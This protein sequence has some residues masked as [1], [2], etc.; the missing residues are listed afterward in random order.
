MRRVI[1]TSRRTLLAALGATAAGPLIGLSTSPAAAATTS[2]AGAPAEAPRAGASASSGMTGPRS[3][4]TLTGAPH[5]IAALTR[6]SVGALTATVLPGTPARTEI[7]CAGQPLA[8]LT[9]GARTVL[10]T[11]PERTFTENKRTFEDRFERTLATA[12]SWGNSPAGGSWSVFGGVRTGTPEEPVYAEFTIPER[13]A[14]RAV[15][16]DTLTGRFA[17][18]R[19]DEITDVDVR[20]NG[21]FDKVPAGN[22]CSFALVFAYSGKDGTDPSTHYRARLSFTTQGGVDLRAEKVLGGDATVLKTAGPLATGVP[23]NTD[24]TIRVRREGARVQI[25]AWR[26]AAVEPAGW[27]MEFTDADPAYAK[28]RVGVRGFASTGCTNLPV[29]MSVS[30]FNVMEASWEKPPSV[31]HSHW[32]RL[33]DAPYDGTWTPAVEAVV[34]GWAGSL[35]PDALSYAA[36][37]LPGAP[38]VTSGQKQPVGAQVLGQAGYGKADGQGL[39]P[40]GADFHDY[41]DRSWSFPDKV[42][43]PEEGQVG[44]LDCSGYVRMVYGYHMGVPLYS[45]VDPAKLALPRKSGAMVDHAPG[46]RVATKADDHRALAA[47]TPIQPGDLVLF[48]ANDPV[49]ANEPYPVDHV[50]IYLGLDTDGLRRFVS[51]RKSSNGPTMA[52]LSGASLLDG[53]GTYALGLRTMRRI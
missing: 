17:T 51:S 4:M 32:V 27:T 21:R 53:T 7:R 20:C 31:T 35:A 18:L 38:Q 14:G 28:G 26:T 49:D 11:G 30:H 29:T 12:G 43:Q 6:A 44:S 50:G 33:L 40:V 3:S 24:W 25:K 23:A 10:M 47:D 8:V 45:G 48:D 9:T 16:S 46:A 19:D 36:M 34:R 52:D 1:N 41:M 42:A 22:A 37:F 13:G 5:D 15:L 39:R 2:P